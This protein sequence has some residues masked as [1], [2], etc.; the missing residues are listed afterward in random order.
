MAHDEYI[1]VWLTASQ[2]IQLMRLAEEDDRPVSVF[3]RRLIEKAID[4]NL[5]PNLGHDQ[6]RCGPARGL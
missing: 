6:G 2:K 1:R 5:V 3:V 4:E